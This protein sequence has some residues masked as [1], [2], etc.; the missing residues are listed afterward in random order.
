M[1]TCSHGS[2][3]IFSHHYFS[4]ASLLETLENCIR[5]SSAEARPLSLWRGPVFI[6]F[7]QLGRHTYGARLNRK[8]P[9][10]FVSAFLSKTERICKSGRGKSNLELATFDFKLRFLKFQAIKQ[11]GNAWRKMMNCPGGN[12]GTRGPLLHPNSLCLTAQRQSEAVSLWCLCGTLSKRTAHDGL[13][14]LLGGARGGSGER[15]MSQMLKSKRAMGTRRG[16]HQ[17][18]IELGINDFC[19]ARFN[20]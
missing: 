15:E 13:S 18:R 10:I 1:F 11:E 12:D 20:Y 16:S 14:T 6:C 19:S 4:E 3:S 7:L 9:E 17:R 2:V 8:G 5:H